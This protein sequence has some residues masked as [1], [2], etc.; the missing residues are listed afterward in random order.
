MKFMLMMNAPG[1]KGDWQVMN[2]QPEDLKAH[3]AFMMQFN[4]ELRNAGEL[5][6][7]EGLAMPGQ[8][9]LVRARADGTPEVTD[10]PFAEAKEFLAGYWIVDVE[11]AGAGVRFGR[12][13]VRGTGSRRQTDQHA[14]RGA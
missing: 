13:R 14:D 7:A 3:I 10:G 8:A 1:G 9:K 2:W 11:S 4:K 5:V 12:P 6:A